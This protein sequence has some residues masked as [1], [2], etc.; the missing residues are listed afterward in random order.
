[1]QLLDRVKYCN[2]CSACA[3]VCKERCVKMYDRKEETVLSILERGEKPQGKNDSK[4][5]PAV[6]ENG[7]TKCNACMLYC[8]LYNTVDMPVF[9]E[10]YR[11]EDKWAKSD[12]PASYR[13]A[14]RSVRAGQ[15]TEFVGTLCEIAALISLMGNKIRPNLILKPLL[16]DEEKRQKEECCKECIFYK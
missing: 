10:W 5:A 15:H 4:K 8:P 1:M 2:G 12:L 9:E 11:Y 6:N 3:V 7:C 16:C 14:M 13:E